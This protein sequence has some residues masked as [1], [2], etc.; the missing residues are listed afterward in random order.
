MAKPQT[1]R[2]TNAKHIRPRVLI[3]STNIVKSCWYKFIDIK[4]ASYTTEI[5][6]PL[7]S[8]LKT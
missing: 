4:H 7:F 3:S 1:Q 8:V 5:I 2:T 6:K